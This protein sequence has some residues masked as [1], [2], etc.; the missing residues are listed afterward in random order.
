MP[1]VG[2]PRLEIW[3]ESSSFRVLK[4]VP[5]ISLGLLM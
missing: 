1:Q 4:A 5:L 2:G 3:A